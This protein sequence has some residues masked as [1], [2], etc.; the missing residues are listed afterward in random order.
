MIHTFGWM[1]VSGRAGM[2][3]TSFLL[4]LEQPKTGYGVVSSG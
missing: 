1:K 2:A 3:V 4:R